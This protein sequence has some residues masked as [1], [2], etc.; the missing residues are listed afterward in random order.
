MAPTI[1]FVDNK[2]HWMDSLL[3]WTND[4]LGLSIFGCRS[5]D[6]ICVSFKVRAVCDNIFKYALV[7]VLRSGIRFHPPLDY[8][9]TP[10]IGNAEHHLGGP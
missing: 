9:Y 7:Q 10:F 3:M 5:Q 1:I 4:P 8:Q 2:I 6:S